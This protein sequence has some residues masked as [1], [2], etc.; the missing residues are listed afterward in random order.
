M[1]SLQHA[2]KTW[3]LTKYGICAAIVS[4]KLKLNIIRDRLRADDQLCDPVPSTPKASNKRY[5]YHKK[6]AIQCVRKIGPEHATES[7]MIV[8]LGTK[9]KDDYADSFLQGLW[10]IHQLEEVLRKKRKKPRKRK[11]KVS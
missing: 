5:A 9:K 7:Q 11:R 10:R 3:F 1:C 8:F 4:P 2:L 6:R